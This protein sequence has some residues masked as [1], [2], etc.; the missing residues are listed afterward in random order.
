[1]LLRHEQAEKLRPDLKA[2]GSATL[3]TNAVDSAGPTPGMSSSFILVSLDRCQAVIIPVEL[4]NLLL[5]PAQLVRAARHPLATSGSRLSFVSITTS[6][7][8]STPLRPIGATIPNSARWARIA[9]VT[10]FS[11]TNDHLAGGI[12]S[13]DLK[14]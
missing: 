11:A 13:V 12:N 2:F 6:S 8:S 10:G 14:D 5:E 7:N 3:A 9:L 4:Q 1:M